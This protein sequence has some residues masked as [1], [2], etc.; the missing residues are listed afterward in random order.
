MRLMVPLA[1]AAALAAIFAALASPALAQ[2]INAFR[3][4]N[5]RNALHI[6]HTLSAMAHAH[7]SS[8]AARQHLDHDG[9]YQRIGTSRGAHAEN[10]AFGCPDIGCA[11]RMW[12]RSNGHRANMLRKDVSAYGIAS[13]SGANG[14]R[15]WVLELGN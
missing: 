8:M 14:Q 4:A 3:R 1:R 6:S 11:I 15:Y 13:A 10:V 12:I 9:F 7:A 2:D 5:G